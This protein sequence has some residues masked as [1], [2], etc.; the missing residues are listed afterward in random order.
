MPS[1]PLDR[2]LVPVDQAYG[3]R[4][5]TVDAMGQAGLPLGPS[6][7][8]GIPNDMLASAKP[9]RMPDM[10]QILAPEPTPK[11][12]RLQRLREVRD[13]TPNSTLRE[14]LDRL[15]NYLPDSMNTRLIPQH[16]GDPLGNLPGK[17]VEDD[18]KYY[19]APP[20]GK[21]GEHLDNGKTAASGRQRE[22][23]R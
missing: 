1:K 22:R 4:Q 5:G 23:P 3:T 14:L 16:L 9:T 15:F 2:A 7:R 12:D 18:N 13:T 8:K 17:R 11:P 21:F 20:F 6:A 10:G 19:D